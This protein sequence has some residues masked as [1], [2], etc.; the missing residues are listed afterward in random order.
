LANTPTASTSTAINRDLLYVLVG[1]PVGGTFTRADGTTA[2]VGDLLIKQRFPLSRINGLADPTFTA[3][4]NSTIL[5][6]VQVPASAVTVQRDFGLKWNTDHWD[7]VGAIG[8]TVLSTI[9][10]LD[11]VV[12]ENREPNFFE[13][14]KAG[15]LSGSVGMGSGSSGRTFVNAETKYY[16]TPLSSDYQIMQIGANIIDQ[17]DSDNVPTFINFGGNELAGIENLPYLNKLVFKPYWTS[18]TTGPSTTYKFDAWLLPSLWNPHQN[19][20]PASQNVQI[21]MTTGTM[22]A[23]TT[24]PNLTSSTIGSTNQYMTVDASLFG[25]VA[26]GNPSVNNPSAPRVANPAGGS[27]I[28][29]VTPGNYYGF[30]FPTITAPAGTTTPTGTAYPTFTACEF[31]MQVQVNGN[32]KS[33]QKWTG[34]AQPAPSLV[35]APGS[36]FSGTPQ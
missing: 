31:A 15:I 2:A 27:N 22:F 36:W 19:A 1:V 34:C 14:L 12:A 8:T 5:N 35:C 28:D 7:Y 9:E 24:S 6:G 11:Q 10:R 29:N 4:T 30:H 20:P 3:T 13:L 33:Y 32:W 17:W 21:A 18:K 23:S 25:T 26:P 16:S